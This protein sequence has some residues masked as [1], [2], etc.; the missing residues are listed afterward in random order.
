MNILEPLIEKLSPTRVALVSIAAASEPELGSVRHHAP[1]FFACNIGGTYC[2]RIESFAN[3]AICPVESDMCAAQVSPIEASYRDSP[4]TTSTCE[5]VSAP[6]PP[7][8]SGNATP[9]KPSCPSCSTIWRGNVSS[10]SHLVECGLI[11]RSAKSVRVSRMRRCS[12]V[13]SKSMTR[14]NEPRRFREPT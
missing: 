7:N 3:A 4:S 8:F 11:S 5:S 13:R 6:P 2:S 1:I 9:R 10:L 12:S 14:S